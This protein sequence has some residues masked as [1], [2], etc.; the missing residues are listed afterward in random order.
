M[1]DYLPPEHVTYADI[2][3]IRTRTGLTAVGAQLTQQRRAGEPYRVISAIYD[4][5]PSVRQA[6][7]RVCLDVIDQVRPSTELVIIRSSN[8]YFYNYRKYEQEIGL[9]SA[10]SVKVRYMRQIY[11][12]AKDIMLLANDAMDRGSTVIS[13]IEPVQKGEYLR[14]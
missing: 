8:P 2:A 13:D 1:T 5:F 6:I 3:I 4:E 11:G 10:V 12:I 14:E 9:V 7:V